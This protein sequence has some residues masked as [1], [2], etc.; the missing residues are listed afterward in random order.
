M[1]IIN[2]MAIKIELEIEAGALQS[3]RVK[4][5]PQLDPMYASDWSRILALD[6]NTTC[7]N[8]AT[9]AVWQL[10]AKLCKEPLWSIRV[11]NRINDVRQY[12]QQIAECL[13]T[14][15]YKTPPYH[16]QFLPAIERQS[17][18]SPL[19]SMLI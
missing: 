4:T 2:E 10:A 14:R 18:R 6:P 13:Q 19:D 9:F 12:G 1:K 7:E 15:P 16:S 5:N 8:P 11:G 3:I 17:N